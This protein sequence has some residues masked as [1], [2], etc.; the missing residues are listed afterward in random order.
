MPRHNGV[1]P[2]CDRPHSEPLDSKCQ[3]LIPARRHRFR[4]RPQ[5]WA[6]RRQAPNRIFRDDPIRATDLESCWVSAYGG[7][8]LTV[9]NLADHGEDDR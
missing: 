4:Q 5:N 2:A 9:Q 6:Q 7:A 1:G 3:L 8:S